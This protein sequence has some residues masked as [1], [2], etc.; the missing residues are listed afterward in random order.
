MGSRPRTGNHEELWHLAVALGLD[1]YRIAHELP[2]SERYGL[3]TQLERA[4]V[5]VAAN[6]AE[7]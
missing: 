6:I 7:G 5:S 1:C 2:D 4:A 3:R